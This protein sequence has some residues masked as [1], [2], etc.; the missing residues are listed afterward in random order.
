MFGL[1]WGCM[2]KISSESLCLLFVERDN[3][4]VIWILELYYFE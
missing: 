2:F 1:F 4:I 3:F